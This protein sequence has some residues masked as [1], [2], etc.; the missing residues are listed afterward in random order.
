MMIV[1]SNTSPLTNL[2]AIGQFELLQRLFE[3]LHI[4]ECVWNE[5]N[6]FNTRWPGAE[7]VGA[8]QWV[9]RH[10]VG[11]ELLVKALRRDIDRG[12]A[13][14]IVLALELRA[15]FVLL[16]E[17]EGRHAAQRMG[18]KPLGVVGIL[19][20]SKERGFSHSV[21]PHLDALR[22]VAGFYLKDSLY[23]HALNLA[24]EAG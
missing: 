12:E 11:D 4:A 19:L 9:H 14:S 15:D 20:E 2:A 5:L 24:G 3:D 7:E 6:A 16:D 13:E 22:E 21:R 17:K 8:A 1:V 18:L 10:A 23:R